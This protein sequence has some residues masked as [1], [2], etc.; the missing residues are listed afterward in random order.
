MHGSQTSA[1]G[2]GRVRGTTLILLFKTINKRS[3]YMSHW[4]TRNQTCKNVQ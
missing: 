4:L 1:S 3:K 2:Q